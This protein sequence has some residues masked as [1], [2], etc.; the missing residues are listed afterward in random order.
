MEKEMVDKNSLAVLILACISLVAGAQNNIRNTNYK[1][2][3]P[4]QQ[5]F[6]ANIRHQEL[7]H[8]MGEDDITNKGKVTISNG[9]QD[10]T[11]CATTSNFPTAEVSDTAAQAG[12]TLLNNDEHLDFN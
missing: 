8:S 11:V 9:T 4:G 10:F 3:E 5:S 2:I 6:E 12:V 1:I 7:C